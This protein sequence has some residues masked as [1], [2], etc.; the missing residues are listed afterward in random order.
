MTQPMYNL[1]DLIRSVPDYPVAGMVYR[2]MNPL[3]RNPAA[4]QQVVDALVMRYKDRAIDAIVGVESRGFI[5]SSPLA[6]Q[7]GVS[8]VPIRKFGKM[9]G[10]AYEVEYYLPFGPDRLQM[11]KGAFER[12]A[13]VVVCDDL[14]A[15]GRTVAAACELVTMA[16]GEIEEVACLLE[17]HAPQGHEKLSGYPVFSLIQL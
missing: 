5:L 4:F 17:L 15:S 7:L 10:P 16:G 11:H 8:F 12:G 1:A 13:R 2:D 3:L 6:Y 9:P 14:I